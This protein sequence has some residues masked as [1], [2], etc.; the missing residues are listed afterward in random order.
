MY[1]YNMLCAI[2]MPV[3]SSNRSRNKILEASFI[4]SSNK[5]PSLLSKA[6]S[7]LTSNIRGEWVFLEHDVNG[8][9]MYSF[10]S[11]LWIRSIFVRCIYV[12]ADSH[13]AS[14]HI[15]TPHH[16]LY[17]LLLIDCW[18]VSS[19]WL[20]WITL[21]GNI[22]TTFGAHVYTTL[23]GIQLGVELVGMVHICEVNFMCQ[24]YWPWV[25]RLHVISGCV[26][27]CVGEIHIWISGPSK[28]DCCPQCV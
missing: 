7:I 17:S 5:Y 11:G 27:K 13:C 3:Y 15:H 1:I 12:I 22:Y 24:Y 19:T 8:I 18:V 4:L 16:A 9:S 21:Q 14:T 6:V 28:V 26:W 23:W 25:P 2:K 10:M 20:L